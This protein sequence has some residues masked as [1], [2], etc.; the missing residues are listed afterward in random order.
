MNIQ[1]KLWGVVKRRFYFSYKINILK[2]NGPDKW[3]DDK[4]I[5]NVFFFEQN[6]TYLYN[7]SEFGL[8]VRSTNKLLPSFNVPNFALSADILLPPSVTFI[9]LNIFG[10]LSSTLEFPISLITFIIFVKVVKFPLFKL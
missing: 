10:W 2:D 4:I 1:P 9:V 8:H 6:K 7:T 3:Y 5:Q